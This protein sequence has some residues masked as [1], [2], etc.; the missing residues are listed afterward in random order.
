MHAHDAV[1][2]L[3]FALGAFSIP[4]L[5]GRIGIPAAVG[6]I[7]FGIV[8]GPHLLGWRHGGAGENGCVRGSAGAARHS[9]ASTA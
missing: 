8:V 1:S 5:S 4:L 3:I 9:R 6:E 7:L 2:L